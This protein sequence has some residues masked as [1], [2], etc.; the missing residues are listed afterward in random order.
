MDRIVFVVLVALGINLACAVFWIKRR[1]SLT[2]QMLLKNLM[3]DVD[4]VGL[5]F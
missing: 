3:E 2:S 1:S 5:I 4:H